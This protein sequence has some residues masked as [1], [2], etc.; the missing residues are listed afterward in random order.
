MKKFIRFIS[1]A[2]ILCFLI[3]GC[4]E[5]P[6]TV[7]EDSSSII[8]TT[9]EV[10]ETVSAEDSAKEITTETEVIISTEA[11]PT[12]K[13]TETETSKETATLAK[14]T[15]NSLAN[16]FEGYTLLEVDGGD[17]S[18][19]RQAN[20]VVDVGYGNREYW[21]FTNEYGQLVKITAK[22]IIPQDESTEPTTSEGRYYPDEA[23]VPGTE[24]DDLDEGHVIADSLGGVANA[25][26]ITPQNSVLN[27][28]GDQ[29]Y[30]E[31][32]IRTA[33]GCTDFVAIITYSDTS[34][35]IPIHYSF[36]YNL[37]GEII[38]DEF[39]NINPEA[40]QEATEVVVE[41][42]QEVIEPVVETPI[43]V[44]ESEADKVKKIDANGNGQVTIKEAKAAGFSMP[45]Y[46]DHWLYKYMDDRDGDGMVGE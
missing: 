3:V 10:V 8:E 24:R 30:M 35:Q 26:N 36:T 14:S 4:T 19:N 38:N 18:G 42:V 46:S 21:A 13:T 39:D 40:T 41:E 15:D 20:V 5:T 45:I 23:K 44:E 7:T 43:V 9:K 1:M 37:M 2:L 25:Y 27:Q 11:V 16:L 22:E 34:T 12:D 29:A 33:G 28:H 6:Q 32:V 31:A 17:I